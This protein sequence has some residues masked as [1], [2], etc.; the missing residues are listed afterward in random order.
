MSKWNMIKVWCCAFL[1]VF[2]LIPA[3]AGADD[4]TDSINEGLKSYQKGEHGSAVESLNYAVQLIQQMKGEG[5]E[6]FLPEPLSGWTAEPASSQASGG[7]MMGGAVAAS[8]AYSKDSSSVDIQIITDSPMMQG[9]MMMFSNPMFATADGGKLE[10][11][12]GEKA[13]VKYDAANREGE[14]QLVVANRFFIVIDG[15]DVSKDDLKSYAQ[16][17]D[18]KK[19]ATV[20]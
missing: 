2:L 13:I 15:S 11:I 7:A 14:I 16:G 20:P 17:I 8:R 19:L 18:F 12:N 6:A 3:F 1:A 10:K 9:V 5:L 4:V